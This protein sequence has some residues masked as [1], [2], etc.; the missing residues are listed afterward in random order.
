MEIISSEESHTKAEYLCV[1]REKGKNA[2][3][4]ENERSDD[5]K[6]KKKRKNSFDNDKKIV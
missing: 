2:W 4:K 3:M 1:G 5:K 6:F